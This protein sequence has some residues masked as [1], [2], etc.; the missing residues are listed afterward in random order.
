MQAAAVS[1]A[2]EQL[3]GK[4]R[5]RDAELRER[6]ERRAEHAGPAFIFPFENSGQDSIQ[7]KGEQTSLFVR[8]TKSDVPQRKV[9]VSE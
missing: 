9:L 2:R 7:N 1:T 8:V 6:D 4:L 5:E 3:H